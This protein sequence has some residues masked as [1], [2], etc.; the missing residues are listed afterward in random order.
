M[1]ARQAVP[2]GL[3]RDEFDRLMAPSSIGDR[4]SSTYKRDRM[5]L[6]LLAGTGLRVNEALTLARYR[7]DLTD[8]SVWI[9]ATYSKSGRARRVYFGAALHEKLQ[10]YLDSLPADQLLLFVTRTGARLEDA[11]VRRL[12]KKAARRCGL[13]P[14]RVHPHAL[15]HTYAIRFLSAGGTLEVLRDQL[16][17]SSISTTAIYL[18]AA[19]WQR[20]EQV[21]K[22]DL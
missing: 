5:L 15:R 3:S 19:S 2:E 17:H 11:H 12:F 4:R 1:G 13:E 6:E 9:E 14:L 8:N 20:A 16:G 7:V 21:A 10:D 22:L 18:Q